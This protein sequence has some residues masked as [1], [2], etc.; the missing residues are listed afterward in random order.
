MALGAALAAL[1][2]VAAQAA[3][4]ASHVA[5]A[6]PAAGAQ[7]KAYVSRFCAPIAMSDPDTGALRQHYADWGVHAASEADAQAFR[8][9]DVEA[10]GQMIAFPDKDAPHAFID[11]RRAMCSLVFP[12]A[13]T[14]EA[15]LE[16]FRTSSLPLRPG[17]AIPWAR[18]TTKRVGRPGPIRYFLAAGEDGRFGLDRGVWV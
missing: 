16:D 17:K 10:P 1:A 6:E 14:P 18:V 5:A 4:A 11:R 8:P 3:P 15:V 9:D 12:T 7:P 2:V 13:R